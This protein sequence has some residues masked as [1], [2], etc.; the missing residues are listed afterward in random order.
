MN[1]NK[2]LVAMCSNENYISGHID[3]EDFS[4]ESTDSGITIKLRFSNK[5]INRI[6]TEN[7]EFSRGFKSD[8]KHD[9][10]LAKKSF[11][12]SITKELKFYKENAKNQDPH[13][14]QFPKQ[15]L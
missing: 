7:F 2:M 8:T 15:I 13:V 3:P 11:M 10:D 9:F 4:V 14:I 6:S 1:E 5:E 12:K